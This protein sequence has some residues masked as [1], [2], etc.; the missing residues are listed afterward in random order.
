MGK[1][2]ELRKQFSARDMLLCMGAYDALSARLVERSGFDCI[3]LG[4]FAA[5]SSMLGVPD[6]G[7]L[8]LTE[9]AD[10]IRAH[11]GSHVEANF[12]G[13]RQWPRQCG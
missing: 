9:M 11:C 4:G 2:Q 5:A 13:C 3:Y 10:H 7:I 8:T 6:L 12:S 1:T